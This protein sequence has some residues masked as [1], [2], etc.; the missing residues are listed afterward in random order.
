MS[1]QRSAGNR[2]GLALLLTLI[3]LVVLSTAVYTLS[4]RLASHIHRQQYIIDYQKAR[5]A[6]DSGMKY[7]IATAQETTLSVKTRN[8]ESETLDFSDIF[9]LDNAQYNKL[10]EQ[11]AYDQSAKEEEN[12]DASSSA[13]KTESKGLLNSLK[14]LLGGLGDI[15]SEE[16][17]YI[18]PNTIKIEGPYG[19]E[20]PNVIEPIEVKI[21]EATVKITIEDENAKLPLT[22]SMMPGKELQRQAEEG[23][24]NFCEWMRMDYADIDTLIE[25]TRDVSKEKKFHM[26]LKEVPLPN[27]ST[28]RPVTRPPS[29]TTGRRTTTSKPRLM[30][31]IKRTRPA[32]AH[33]TDFSRLMHSS[34]IDMEMLARP[35]PE[36]NQRYESPLKYIGVW[37][38]KKVNINTAPRHVLEAAFAFGGDYREIAD[39]IIRRRRIKPFKKVNEL[40]TDFYGYSDSIKIV[41]NYLT[42]QSTCLTIKVTATSGNA[43]TSSIAVIIKNGKNTTKIAQLSD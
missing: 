38:T 31:T 2:Q 20:W 33:Q 3:V 35:V 11:I 17:S 5:Y 8:D 34:Y 9:Y 1:A 16:N 28:L 12:A 10:L 22:W 36:S 24:T 15:G 25:Q 37:G 13:D 4:S 23:L 39:E 7:A 30:G 6:C 32:E 18:D 27:A 29:R 19:P 42:T 40:E 21:A 14:G 43:T 41:K 26:N